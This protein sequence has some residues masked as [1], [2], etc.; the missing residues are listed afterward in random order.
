[1]TN[2]EKQ[3]LAHLA[4]NGE[5]AESIP[6]FLTRRKAFSHQARNIS[7]SVQESL[8]RTEWGRAEEPQ[9]FHSQR[10]HKLTGGSLLPPS[11]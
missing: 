1:M 6:S 2:T 7:G 3:L 11:G 8:Y 5:E 4:G 10:L 9:W